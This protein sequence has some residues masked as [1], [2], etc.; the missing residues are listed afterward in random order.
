MELD[1]EVRQPKFCK[2]INEALDKGFL[3]HSYLIETSNI[4]S[5]WVDKYI[6]YFVKSIY[7]ISKNHTSKYHLL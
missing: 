5:E 1:V 2:Q 4:D 6:R 3:S 7:N